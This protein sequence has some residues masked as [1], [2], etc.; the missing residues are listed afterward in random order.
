MILS[1][2]FRFL[3]YIVG[4]ANFSVS[5]LNDTSRYCARCQYINV[6]VRCSCVSVGKKCRLPT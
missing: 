4:E 6:G 3:A 5:M 1:F 2:N